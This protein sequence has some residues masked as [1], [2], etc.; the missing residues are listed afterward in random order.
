MDIARSTYHADAEKLNFLAP[1]DE[2]GV[3]RI[4]SWAS[5]KTNEKIEEVITPDDVDALTAMVI[6]NAIYFKGTWVTQFPAEAT[7]QS[8]F[9]KNST[10]SVDADFMH[11]TGVFNYTDSDGVQVLKMPYEGDRLSMLVV[12]P[13]DV[14]GMG[15]PQEGLSAE[16]IQK[17]QHGMTETEVVVSLPKF[18]MKTKY[19]LGDY[20]FPPLGMTDAFDAGAA[21][22]LGILGIAPDEEY[23]GDNLYVTKATQ[24]AYVKVNEEGTEAAAVTTIVTGMESLSLP[25]VFTADRPFVF[26]IQ[27]DESGAVLFMGR[28]S[29]PTA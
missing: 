29:D 15:Q 14:D 13:S 27:D 16:L 17:W 3:K 25:P 1:G 21:D 19:D 9:W 22:L 23:H 12:L 24:D 28:T 18:E 7:G 10:H 4:N 8:G 2:G 5:E 6:S 11:V 26:M 20:L